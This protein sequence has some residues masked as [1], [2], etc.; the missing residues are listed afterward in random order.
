MPHGGDDVKGQ[1]PRAVIVGAGFGGLTVA[2][3]HRLADSKPGP[4]P[5]HHTRA[6]AHCL[7]NWQ[8]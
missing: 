2:G 3:R 6:A 1:R 8:A 4:A 5:A 7:M